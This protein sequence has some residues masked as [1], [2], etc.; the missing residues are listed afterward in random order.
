VLSHFN[1]SL[2]EQGANKR[3]S[4]KY[5]QEFLERQNSQKGFLLTEI[6]YSFEFS[7]FALLPMP[8]AWMEVTKIQGFHELGMRAIVSSYAKTS[9]K[10]FSTENYRQ[11]QKINLKFISIF[12]FYAP[13]T[14]SSKS[15]T[16]TFGQFT[17]RV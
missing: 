15:D 8:M 14:A 17:P 13:S 10:H 12:S 4:N 7:Y 16:T 9:V 5:K 6:H 3:M 2:F 1:K 11:T